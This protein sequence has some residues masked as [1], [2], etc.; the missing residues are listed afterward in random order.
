[1][2]NLDNNCTLLLHHSPASA[3][4]VASESDLA[5]QLES[6]DDDDK[7]SALK[8]LILYTLNGESFPKL[9][10]C[11][12]KFC[13][14]SENHQIK[15]LLLVYW[16]VVDKRSEDGKLL[17][18]MILVC[19]AMKNNLVHANEYI[20][21]ST[22]R[23]LCK[24]QIEEILESLIPNITANLEH[25]HSYV[26][27]NAVLTVFTIFQNFPDLIADAP[28][29]IE[30]FLN[31]EA[32]PSAIHNAFLM[33]YHCDTDR[34]VKFLSGKLASITSTSESFQ[35]LVLELVRKVCRTNPYAKSQYIRC[36]DQLVNGNSHA[37]SFEGANTLVALSANPTAVRAAVQAYCR[38][39]AA[40]SDN[41]IKLIILNRLVAL[42]RRNE[43]IL[44]EMLMDILRTLA[45]PNI[46]I[47]RKTLS[48]ALD[49]VTPNN[50]EEVVQLLK[51]EMVTTESPESGRGDKYRKLLVDAMHKCAVKFPDVVSN[52]VHLLMNYLGDEN[53][54]SAQDVIFFV[55]EIVEEYP[56][57]RNSI[58]Q[59][60]MDSFDE[61]RV[62][63]VYGV[64]LWIIGEYCVDRD[65]V[66]LALLTIRI[67]LG[68]MPFIA[69]ND[70]AEDADNEEGEEKESRPVVLSDGTYASSSAAAVD[71]D[72]DKKAALA[73]TLRTM[74]LSGKYY[75]AA[76]LAN[77]LTKLVLKLRKLVG[78]NSPEANMEGAK[79]L[80]ILVSAL[81]LGKAEADKQMDMDSHLRITNCIRLLLDSSAANAKAKRFFVE[82]S[83]EAF[84]IMLE[85]QRKRQNPVDKDSDEIQVVKQADD[86]ISIRQLSGRRM[87][88]D[89]M[90]DDEED[91]AQAVGK[92]GARSNKLN[93]VY[94]LTGFADP[95]YAEASLTVLEYDIVLDILVINQ[96]NSTLQNLAVELHTSGDLKVVD[97]PQTHTI[98][99]NGTQNI[100]ANVKV[101]STES[102]VIFGNI[103]YDSA[104]GVEKTVVVLNNI[105]M[106]IMDYISPAI[107][108]D[109]QFRTMWAEFEWENKVAVITDIDDLNSYLDHVVKIT[110]M[111]CQTPRAALSGSC[112][113]LAANLYAK[114]LFGEDALLN[115]SVEKQPNSKISGYIRIRS[116]TQGIALSLGDKITAFQRGPKTSG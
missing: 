77:A 115:L 30:N 83:R 29:L 79:A 86:L 56:Q 113:F 60:L 39:L 101:T 43:K 92:N 38:L 111:K 66:E 47:R 55:R 96:T 1:M 52:V 34:A 105:D 33:L 46:D 74:L 110:N 116:K 112:N 88:L 69:L 4:A 37:V 27:K 109:N 90:D 16:E 51:K 15:K 20:R 3:N 80:Q 36:I 102:G 99:P 26:R 100:K 61:I 24:L 11:V 31:S 78:D 94:Q 10:M 2:T 28:E 72:G 62:A 42:K 6:K 103:V 35:L 48:L 76:S 68:D 95:I 75:L 19:N 22:L 21:G 84:V 57:L 44:Q 7:V 73:N 64:A 50:V 49:L 14:H 93:R 54:S 89:F 63:S 104:S 98:P 85:D 41:N 70:K 81:R 59:K 71:G 53:A 65:S 18:E 97:R 106:D 12:I 67:S 17:H 82:K 25:R 8:L 32:N 5:K 114:S 45:S 87:D 91:L 9:L 40:E 58:L 13:L 23:F 108:S 107:T